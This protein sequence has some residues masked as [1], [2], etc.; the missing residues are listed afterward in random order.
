MKQE[1][2]TKQNLN[3]KRKT[4]HRFVSKT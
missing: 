4:F 3:R 2:T 1:F